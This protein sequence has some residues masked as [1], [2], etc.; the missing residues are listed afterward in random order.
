MLP[1]WDHYR[2]SLH[3]TILSGV[4]RGATGKTMIFGGILDLEPQIPC[5]W[6][7]QAAIA[8]VR[9]DTGIL[10]KAPK[11]GRKSVTGVQGPGM[12]HSALC[13]SVVA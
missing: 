13:V 3:G 9:Q 5:Q 2:C 4:P 10:A 7:G 11:C 1:L 6:G 8:A 12:A